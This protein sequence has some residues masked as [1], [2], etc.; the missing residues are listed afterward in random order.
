MLQL[1]QV[2]EAGVAWCGPLWTLKGS[3]KLGRVIEFECSGL[4][5]FR[6]GG[7]L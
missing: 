4:G 3:T 7:K 1:W 6:M 2:L 5:A